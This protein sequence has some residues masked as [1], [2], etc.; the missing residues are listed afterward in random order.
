MKLAMKISKNRCIL[1]AIDYATKWGEAPTI[2]ISIIVVIVKF[3][4]ENVFTWFGCPLTI[5]TDQ[6]RHFI[7]DAIKYLID[8]FILEHTNHSI[9]RKQSS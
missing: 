6:G 1:I 9:V 5:V 3:L 7:N 2:Y 8:H 4:Y